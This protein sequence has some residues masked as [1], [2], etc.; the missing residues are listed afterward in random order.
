MK[1]IW[2]MWESE[3][4][5]DTVQKIIQE[6]EYYSPQEANVGDDNAK[7]NNKVR[8]S[9][10]RWIDPNDQNSNFIKKLLMLYAKRANRDAFGVSINEVYDIQYTIYDAKDDGHYDW[11]FD[12]FWA[13]D[14]DLRLTSS[15]IL[16]AFPN[17]LLR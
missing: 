17:I 1:S 8:S 13:N 9:T 16:P 2:Q 11:H 14:L 7:Q 15:F 6:C 4:S 10:V 5:E 3:L 12:T